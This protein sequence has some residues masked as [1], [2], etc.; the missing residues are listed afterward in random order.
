VREVID[1]MNQRINPSGEL[2]SPE[3]GLANQEYQETKNSF[4]QST[5]G[6]KL[7]A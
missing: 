4:A 6:D 7:I 1:P 2:E 3:D 5:V